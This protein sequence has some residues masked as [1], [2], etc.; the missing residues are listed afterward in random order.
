MKLAFKKQKGAVIV[1]TAIGILLFLGMAGLALDSS[2]SFLNKT[3]LQNAVDAAA[4]AGANV[5]NEQLGGI[6]GTPSSAQVTAAKSAATTKINS[7]FLANV[8]A[9]PQLNVSI[10]TNPTIEFSNTLFD[11]ADSTSPLYVR[12]T[13]PTVSYPSWFMQVLG[14]SQKNVATTAV[15][16][17]SP[18][19]ICVD[20]LVPIMLCAAGGQTSG[21]DGG[22]GAWGY[23]YNERIQLNPK[24]SGSEPSGNFMFLDS[25]DG[26]NSADVLR[27]ALAGA[28]KVPMLC[29]GSKPNKVGTNPGGMAGPMADGL[30]TRFGIYDG[31]YGGNSQA[32]Q[33]FQ[34]AYPGDTNKTCYSQSIMDSTSYDNY[35]A[36]AAGIADPHG[37]NSSLHC[38]TYQTGGSP[39]SQNGRRNL[40]IPIVDCD[41]THGGVTPGEGNTEVTVL[42]LGCLFLD[43]PADIPGKK[44][45][46]NYISTANPNYYGCQDSGDPEVSARLI[47]KCPVSG[48][49][50]NVV[51]NTFNLKV[52]QLYKNPASNDS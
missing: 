10:T 8:Q 6:T 21:H 4:L 27:D 11:P 50:G 34:E 43:V 29:I 28:G 40:I 48:F 25:D 5:L 49:S 20:N 52:I 24:F 38:N 31:P 1:F 7:V 44:E 22:T 30:N 37:A 18:K 36:G 2:H 13:S 16:G 15:A 47:K 26:S 32:A 9:N 46:C 42:D 19:T 14:Y 45:Y 39:G 23:N 51:N 35:L 17:I 12:V 41:G 3:R 33:A